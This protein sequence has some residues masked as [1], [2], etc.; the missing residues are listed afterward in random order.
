M[1]RPK[2]MAVV[3]SATKTASRI[4]IVVIAILIYVAL[5]AATG[6]TVYA[7]YGWKGQGSGPEGSIITAVQGMA[8]IATQQII[9][10]TTIAVNPIDPIVTPTTPTINPCQPAVELP[11]PPLPTCQMGY[12]MECQPKL[13]TPPC[14]IL[15]APVCQTCPSPPNCICQSLIP[16][17]SLPGPPVVKS[18]DEFLR[19]Q[20]MSKTVSQWLNLYP[21]YSKNRLIVVTTLLDDMIEPWALVGS[22]PRCTADASNQFFKTTCN[23]CQDRYDYV[24]CV[25]SSNLIEEQTLSTM[26]KVKGWFNDDTQFRQMRG[27]LPDF[28]Y[29][30]WAQSRIDGI[31]SR[32]QQEINA[33]TVRT[34]SG[35]SCRVCKDFN[36]NVYE[37]CYSRPPIRLST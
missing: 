11:C 33:M 6:A 18:I 31:M 25:M 26:A 3:N 8:G 24:K 36:R 5:C 32:Y 22:F 9:P 21:P 2:K 4:A 17:P 12:G 15:P 7:I 16:C 10:G 1:Y 19:G 37:K 35:S 23:I 27:W 34:T 14:Y 28:V 20:R 13:P 30:L 29:Q